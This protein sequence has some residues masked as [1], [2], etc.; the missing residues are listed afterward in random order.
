MMRQEIGGGRPRGREHECEW[1]RPGEQR[2]VTSVSQAS[3][4]ELCAGGGEI[5]IAVASPTGRKHSRN[6]DQDSSRRQDALV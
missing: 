5:S 2:V 3:L 6:R 1:A 4:L